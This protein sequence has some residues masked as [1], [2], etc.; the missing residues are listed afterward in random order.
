MALID[1]KKD[2]KLH[3]NLNYMMIIKVKKLVIA[4][5]NLPLK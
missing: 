2:R 5:L 1:I 3:A 4:G